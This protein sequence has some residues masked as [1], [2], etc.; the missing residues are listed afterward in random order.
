[1][2]K[3]AFLLLLLAGSLSVL[4][5]PDKYRKVMQQ[6]IGELDSALQKGSMGSLANAFERIAEAEKNQWLP[7]YYASYCQVMTALL[8]QDKAKVDPLADKAEALIKKAAALAGESN[9][10]IN[11]IYSMIATAHLTVDPP[12]RWMQYGQASA[13]FLE[14]AKQQD[15]TNPRPVYLEGQSKFY[16]PEQFG[17][18]KAAAAVVLEQSL[19]LFDQFKPAS[20]LHPTWGKTSAQYFLAQCK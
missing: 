2:K 8:E 4:A 1:M 12:A 18:G 3:T 13:A 20:E 15:P 11:V 14:K 7:Y 9:S 5:Q 17:G 6:R 10:E 16:T 19:R